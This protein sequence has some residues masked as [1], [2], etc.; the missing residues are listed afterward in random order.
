VT[1]RIANPFPIFLDRRGFPLDGGKVYIGTDGDDPEA[2][3]VDLFSDETLTTPLPQPVTVI[4]GLMTYDGNPVQVFIAT[5]GYSIR[6]RDADGAQVFYESEAV[7]NVTSW[8]PLDSDLT[9]IAALTT[10]AYGRSLLT[11]ASAAALL[12]SL[13]AAASGANVDITSLKEDVAL[14]GGTAI[15]PSTLGF[16]GLPLSGQT[17]G[18]L[19]TLALSDASKRVA[20]TT[21]GWT[22]P[23]NAS[24][25]FPVGTVI[26]LHNNSTVAQNVAITTDTMTLEGTTT[27]GTRSVMANGTARLLKTGS[28]SW[29]IG[30]SVT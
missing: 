19:I 3:P 25:A 9:A 22:V 29:L 23:A 21:G 30:G 24:V 12:S 20:N 10:T 1:T 5:E 17:Q 7:L 27:T 18:S 15:T 6:A 4:G 11:S 2:S 28:T 16:R 8:Q 14:S 13:G 26:V